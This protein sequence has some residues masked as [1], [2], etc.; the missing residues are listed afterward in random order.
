MKFKRLSFFESHAEK[1]IFV[2]S[3]VIAL[4]VTW[5]FVLQSPATVQIGNEIVSP[6]EVGEHVNRYVDELEMRIT[7]RKSPLPPLKTP[8]YAAHFKSRLAAK[9]S[10]V[11]WYESPFGQPGLDL[12]PSSPCSRVDWGY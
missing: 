9:I 7:S 4:A 12:T 6:G 1:F 10:A 8:Q 5:T 11:E 3:L 2:A